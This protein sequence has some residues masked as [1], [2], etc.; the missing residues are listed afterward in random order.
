MKRALILHAVLVTGMTTPVADSVRNN[1]AGRTQQKR[2]GGCETEGHTPSLLVADLKTAGLWPDIEMDERRLLQSNE[3]SAQ[4][5][6]DASW[7]GES[8]VCLLWALRMILELPPYDQEMDPALTGLLR[9]APITELI[10]RA[11]L[12]PKKQIEKQREAAELWHW[13]AQAQNLLELENSDG[14]SV[15]GRTIGQ[16]IEMSAV[17]GARSGRLPKPIAKDF[18]ALGKP[19]CELSSVEF[20]TLASIA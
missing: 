6:I 12:R 2:S 3:I 5:R 18:P 1:V 14:Q 7:L 16:M 17:K 19:Y 20:A 9:S 4:Q 8:I 11:K 10:V 15:G 13:R